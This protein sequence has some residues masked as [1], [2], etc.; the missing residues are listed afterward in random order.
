MFARFRV[1]PH[2]LQVSL[3]ET[4][5]TDGRVRH[6][7]VAALGSAQLPLSP[8]NRL[9][10]WEQLHPRLARLANRLDSEAQARTLAS[11]HARI[12]MVNADERQALQIE[13]AKRDVTFWEVMRD[14]NAELSLGQQQLAQTAERN[15]VETKKAADEAAEHAVAAQ[16][17]L[18]RL[19]HGEPMATATSF[20]LRQ[21]LREL[22]V[23]DGEIRHWGNVSRIHQIGA[24]EEYLAAITPN[25][26]HE[27]RVARKI[28]AKRELP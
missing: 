15:S 18:A 3:V 10:F 22:G 5:R 9:Q 23:T 26:H 20:D 6:E 17:R 16:D 1:T 27:R 8:Q 28:L 11:I 2:R 4:R 21:K 13:A 19:E 14:S 7:H 12:P 24:D 25:K